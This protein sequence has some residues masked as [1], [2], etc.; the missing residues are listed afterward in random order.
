MKTVLSL[1]L[2]AGFTALASAQA[3]APSPSS[4]TFVSQR[5]QQL[6]NG[7]MQ[8]RGDVKLSIVGPVEIQADE[9]DATGNQREFALRG[10]V[11]VKLP[12][13]TR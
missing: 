9:A 11:I 10:N 6:P 3:T 12:A 8:L 7:V 13:E 2:I 1:V 5:F 4:L